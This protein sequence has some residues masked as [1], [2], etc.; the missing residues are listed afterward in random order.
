MIP[1][2][3][4]Q[5]GSSRGGPRIDLG[6]R[7]LLG[8]LVSRAWRLMSGYALRRLDAPQLHLRHAPSPPLKRELLSL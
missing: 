8:Y 1:G 2:D 3:G 6:S 7:H 4:V 5:V